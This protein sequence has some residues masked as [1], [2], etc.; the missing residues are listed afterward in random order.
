[1]KVFWTRAEDIQH[2]YY[3]PLSLNPRRVAKDRPYDGGRG[4][5]SE[6]YGAPTGY[7][8]AVG[9]FTDSFASECFADEVA[10]SIGED[11]LEFRL[12]MNGNSPREA[13][14]RLAAEKAGWGTPLPAGW[15]RGIAVFSTWGASHVAMVAEVSVEAGQ[16]RVHRV[17]CG[18][19]CGLVV[20]P[21]GVIAQIEGGVVFGLSALLH[22]E[23]TLDKGRVQQSNFH[24][25][26]ILRL[27]ETPQIEV[28]LVESTATVPSGIGEMADPVIAP[29]VANAIYQITGKRIRQIPIRPAD[30]QA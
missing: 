6:S 5:S 11:P 20:N 29:A 1:V 26:P 9:E 23:I 10:G 17:V 2:D 14:L 27:D 13:V 22:Q 7:W 4:G 19:D 15:G 12:K 24:D 30:L 21:D 8:R 16:V 3:H 25:Y 18:V 28:Y